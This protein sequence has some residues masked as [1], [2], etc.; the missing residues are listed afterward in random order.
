MI[1]CKEN[2]I[3]IVNFFLWFYEVLLFERGWLI[4]IWFGWLIFE[5]CGGNSYLSKIKLNVLL[6]MIGVK[7]VKLMGWF[8]L[9]IGSDGF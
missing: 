2:D 5:V 1:F 9:C 4:I 6:V 8:E 7:V 3:D